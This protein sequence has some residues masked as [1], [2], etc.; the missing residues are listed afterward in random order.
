MRVRIVTLSIVASVL[1]LAAAVALADN[2]P[3]TKPAPAADVTMTVI[4]SGQDVV[5][6]VVQTIVVPAK[7]GKGKAADQSGQQTAAAAKLKEEGKE[8]AQ[9]EQ[10]EATPTTGPADEAAEQAAQQ[11]A[12][13][14]AEHQAAAAQQ[15]QQQ[16]QQA[17]DK[18]KTTSGH[19][20]V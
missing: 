12:E 6:T 20:P 9:A 3:V 16:A 11:Q 17:R 19:P 10:H 18:R 7:R 8:S 14:A 15:A 1:S 4:P 5:K 13:E 2:P